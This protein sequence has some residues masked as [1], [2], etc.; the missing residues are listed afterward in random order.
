MYAAAI[1]SLSAIDQVAALRLALAKAPSLGP[2]Q[3]D[4]GRR[5]GRSSQCRPR[6]P[7]SWGPSTMNPRL[8]YEIGLMRP[9]LERLPF[10][11]IP[12][13]LFLWLYH[14]AMLA[15]TE[16]GWVLR[17]GDNG[18]NAL[19]MHA[20]LHRPD[21]L[22]HTGLLNAP[23]G[24]SQLFTDSNP[25]LGLVLR[26]FSPLLPAEA[27]FVGPWM[28]LCLVL[29]VW[30]SWK[31]LRPYAPTPIALWAGVLLM[32]LLPTLFNRYVHVN[33]MAHWL[34][35]WAL[36][37]FVDARRAGNLTA[38]AAVMIVSVLIHSY[39]FVMV[40]AIWGSAM[41]ERFATAPD[42]RERGRLALAS[43]LILAVTGSLGLYLGAGGEF[44]RVLGY[45]HFAMSLD[46][47]WNPNFPGFSKFLPASPPGDQ[48][49]YEGFQYLGLG[50]LILAAVGVAAGWKAERRPVEDG[51]YRRLLWLLPALIVLT[52]LALST[53]LA[54][55]GAE[56]VKLPLPEFLNPVTDALRASGQ[57][58]WP[59]SYTLVFAATVAAYR[60]RPRRREAVLAALVAVQLFDISPM[61]NTIRAWHYFE[62]TVPLNN[63]TR[64]AR[65]DELIASSRDISFEAPDVTRDLGR[66]QEIAWRAASHGVPVRQ[67]YLSRWPTATMERYA[68]ESAAF[69]QGERVPGRLYVILA[70]TVPPTGPDTEIVDGVT[71]VRPR[72]WTAEPR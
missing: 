45:G 53:T 61:S 24:T 60:L 41:L 51:L 1:S 28:L 32:T 42:W 38:W 46:G 65:W 43:A 33:L 18:E 68:R 13:L 6:K 26:L 58:F 9:Y 31:L 15:P 52:L 17:G 3:A 71:V 2:E 35:L 56:L 57:M 63:F 5:A 36:W 16:L 37:L 11:L 22:M 59:C 39:L 40:A 54:F 70:G 72:R 12:L 66:F 47:L 19:G 69:Q 62:V 10:L 27:Q 25:L 30:F 14:P 55:A 21:G 7:L 23:E 67:A 64:S 29:H 8:R 34:I 4:L 48:R 44:V 49:A 20:Y 50:L